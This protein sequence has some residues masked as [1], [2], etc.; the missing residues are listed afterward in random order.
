MQVGS[1][2]GN[3]KFL[4][5]RKTFPFTFLDEE[6]GSELSAS[7]SLEDVLSNLTVIWHKYKLREDTNERKKSA[8]QR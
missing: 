4:I 8:K 1:C 3:A 6:K 2:L 5:L 7:L